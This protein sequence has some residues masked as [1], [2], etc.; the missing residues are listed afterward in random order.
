M[1]PMNKKS[2]ILSIPLILAVLIFGGWFLLRKQNSAPESQS[3]PV[4][5]EKGDSILEIPI[6]SQ[7]DSVDTSDWK[8]YQN[9]T[10]FFK[11]PPLYEVSVVRDGLMV[12]GTSSRLKT[13]YYS[14][15][16]EEISETGFI[17]S[18]EITKL[19][20]SAKKNSP[21]EEDTGSLWRN[22]VGRDR[23]GFGNATFQDASYKGSEMIIV[24]DRGTG[25]LYKNEHIF[26]SYSIPND[27]K[28]IIA[29][30]A[31]HAGAKE[32]PQFESVALGVAQTLR[33][34]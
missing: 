8:M 10:V 20:T 34:R 13:E 1:N 24:D 9:E 19:N 33:F 3:P 6:D 28:N 32:F 4:V 7:I 30:V 27:T 31:I 16:R 5:K 11:Y 12:F 18:V 25:S 29:E 15:G 2:L 17:A 22:W 23:G 21:G 26:R 14:G